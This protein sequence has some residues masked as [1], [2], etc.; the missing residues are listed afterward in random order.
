MPQNFRQTY[1]ESQNK[2]DWI[3]FPYLK[4]RK[5]LNF[6]SVIMDCFK[7]KCLAELVGKRELFD[8]WLMLLMNMKAVN[9]LFAF[10]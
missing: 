8:L 5:M 7:F 10:H 6:A 1:C 9:Q 2:D 4:R 3:Y